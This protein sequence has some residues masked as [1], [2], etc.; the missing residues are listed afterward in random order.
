M[1]KKKSTKPNFVRR[2]FSNLGPGLITGA[3]DDDPSGIAT[4]SSRNY[5]AGHVRCGRR[6]VF[7]L[8]LSTKF[9]EQL[10]LDLLN[11]KQ[12]IVLPPQ[13]VIEF[14]VQMPDFQLGFQIHFVIVFRAQTIARLGAVL[15]HHNDGRLNGCETREDQI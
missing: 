13:E 1:A 14:F 8:A 12:P 5:Y 15:T 11:L 9:F 10:D 3:A 7:A 6:N 2:F 4:Y